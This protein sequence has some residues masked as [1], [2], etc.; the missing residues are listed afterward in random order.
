MGEF[1][2]IRAKESVK[3]VC[4]LLS[5]D[6]LNPLTWIREEIGGLWELAE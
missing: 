6:S 2:K 4:I 1:L 5:L 3:E